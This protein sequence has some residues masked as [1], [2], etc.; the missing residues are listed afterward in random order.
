MQY[1]SFRLGKEMYALDIW[2]AREIVDAPPLNQLPNA[3]AWLPGMMNLRGQVVPVVDLK[4]KFGLNAGLHE[5]QTPA[6]VIVVEVARK[7]EDPITVGVLADEV[8]EVFDVAAADL[9]APPAFG[10][11]YSRSYLLG[12]TKRAGAIVAV[13][14][15][16]KVLSDTDVL[17]PAEGAV[18]S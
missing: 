15:A 17:V 6:Y 8:I 12:M 11:R 14:D 4:E 13:M 5:K 7:D 3:P 2:Q 16:P 9:D 1:V 10:A 18:A